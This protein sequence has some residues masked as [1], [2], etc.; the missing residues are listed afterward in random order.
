MLVVAFSLMAFTA[1]RGYNGFA[2]FVWIYGIFLGGYNYALKMYIYEKV[3]ARN[4]AR[5]WGFAQCAMALPVLLGIPL[6]GNEESLVRTLG[7]KKKLKSRKIWKKMH[8]TPPRLTFLFL[9]SKF[10]QLRIDEDWCT[11]P[12]KPWLRVL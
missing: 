12:K 9:F 7:F 2:M 5:A 11:S 8:E 10:H 1:I 6:S 4:F 3:R